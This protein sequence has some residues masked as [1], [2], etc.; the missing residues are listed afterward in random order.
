[1][2]EL[3]QHE[4]GVGAIIDP[5]GKINV[6]PSVVELTELLKNRGPGGFGAAWTRG[7]GFELGVHR[8]KG[9]AKKKG[10]HISD[11][12][13]AA[14]LHTLY[15]TNP[16]SNPH[17]AIVQYRDNPPLAVAFNGNQANT[18][19]EGVAQ[20]FLRSRDFATTTS[21]DTELIARTLAVYADEL[22]GD[23]HQVF[24]KFSENFPD[25]AYNI[26]TL[27]PD[28][29]INVFRDPEGNRP[30]AYG[31]TEDG[32]QAIASEDSSM[33]LHWDGWKQIDTQSFP[34][35]A[36]LQ[37]G[38]G[39]M[40]P[41]FEII[42][43]APHANRCVLEW[44][45]LMKRL[46]TFDDVEARRVRWIC[47]EILAK[48]DRERMN[49]W[50][51]PI[52]IGVPKTSLGIVGGYEDFSGVRQMNVL[53]LRRNKENQEIRE[54]TFI[55]EQEKDGDR[56]EKV[57]M[58]FNDINW[59]EIHGRDIVLIDDSLVRGTTMKSIIKMKFRNPPNAP[60]NFKA[61][62]HARFAFPAVIAP[63]FFGIDI[64]DVNQ[65]MVPR[66]M[67]GESIGDVPSEEICRR[68]AK[69]IDADSVSFLPISG[70][71]QA[72]GIPDNELCRS[73]VTGQYRTLTLQN[74]YDNQIKKP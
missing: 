45:Y 40:D 35:G 15:K 7:E 4:C 25:A 64:A 38:P 9:T 1:M 47:G 51:N 71:S 56:D 3:I 54:R 26:V 55:S 59:R 72:I 10:F 57:Q 43:R 68:V 11:V 41:Q 16:A 18:P 42:K 29:K 19:S 60:K 6:A 2:S 67:T 50:K 61:R 36:L 23:M 49:E 24:A 22:R 21:S 30:L 5:R 14:V 74:L 33:K 44:L 13:Y 31:R 53:S 27:S 70:L 39:I 28:G 8:S 65:L 52:A 12:T 69:E 48:N 34:R 17:P 62:I 66:L 63:C 58:K 46:S 37:M 32:L 73:C 20:E